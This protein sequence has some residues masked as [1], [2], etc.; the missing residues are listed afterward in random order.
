MFDRRLHVEP[1]Q[2]WLLSGND[3]IHVVPAAEAVISHGKKCIRVGRQ[4]DTYDV[5]FLVRDVIDEAGVLVR[6]PVMVLTPDM[7]RQQII[8]RGDGAPPWDVARHLQ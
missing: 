1:L 7:R 2:G 4:I 6:E 3:Y 8:Q 5:R